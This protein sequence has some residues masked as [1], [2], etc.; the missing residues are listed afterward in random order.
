MYGR[1][2]NTTYLYYNL[3]DASQWPQQQIFKNN[4]S[5]A[6]NINI[7]SQ[8]FPNAIFLDK[9]FFRCWQFVKNESAILFFLCALVYNLLFWLIL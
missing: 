6:L 8:A 5:S 2:Q 4:I 9:L 1:Q 7:K 3:K